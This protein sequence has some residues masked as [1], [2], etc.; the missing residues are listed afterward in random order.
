M[1]RYLAH[2]HPRKCYPDG[3]TLLEVMVALAVLA[4]ALTSIYKLQGQT[5]LMSAKSRFL[6]IAPQLAQAKLAEVERQR[7]KDIGDGSGDFGQDHPDYQWALSIEE[8]PMELFAEPEKDYHM[9][10]IN[11]NVTRNDEDIYQLR[12]YRF[13]TDTE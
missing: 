3:F 2:M 5:I 13:F 6:V 12:T 11:I 8:I 10:A 4:I 7:F 1:D 9:V